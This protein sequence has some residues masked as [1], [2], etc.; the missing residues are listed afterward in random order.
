M[1]VM[2]R[3]S[4][5]RGSDEPNTRIHRFLSHSRVTDAREF[6]NHEKN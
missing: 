4:Y 3:S 5:L 1:T 6:K 2:N